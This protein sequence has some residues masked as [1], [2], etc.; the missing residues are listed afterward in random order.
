M[1]A[2]AGPV[3]QL[4]NQPKVKWGQG[5]VRKSIEAPVIPAPRS[6]CSSPCLT[7]VTN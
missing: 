2:A 6:M 7:A 3:I 4:G 5:H 1:H